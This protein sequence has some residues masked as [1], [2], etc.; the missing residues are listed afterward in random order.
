MITEEQMKTLFTYANPIP[1]PE[2][3]DLGEV[4]G[5][6]YLATLQQRSSNMTQLDTRLTEAS[7]KKRPVTTWLVAAMAIVVIGVVLIFTNQSSDAPVATVPTPTTVA[8]GFESPVPPTAEGLAGIWHTDG[9]QILVR[10]SPDGTY[11]L[12]DRGNLDTDPRDTGTYEIEGSTVTF[13]SSGD[14]SFCG[15]GSQA[16]WQDVGFTH[17]DR[18][19]GTVAADDC[20][21]DSVGVEFTMI[22]VS[23]GR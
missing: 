11:A 13:S 8:D 4:R 9:K 20:F 16:V 18:L 19:E 7:E 5:T 21:V 14:G 23:R 6:A 22:L 2:E 15:A 10:F 3:I 12:D 17:V 1:E